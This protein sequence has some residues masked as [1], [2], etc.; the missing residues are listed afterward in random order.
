MVY[1]VTLNQILCSHHHEIIY[2]NAWYF[3]KIFTKLFCS[4]LAK[5]NFFHPLVALYILNFLL[6]LCLSCWSQCYPK[7]KSRF[8]CWS[9]LFHTLCILVSLIVPNSVSLNS[10]FSSCC[11]AHLPWAA[12]GVQGQ[13]GLVALFS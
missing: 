11:R 8:C 13:V 4:L 2:A 7:H 6:Q 5:M 9:G 3:A 12:Y 1:N 10:L